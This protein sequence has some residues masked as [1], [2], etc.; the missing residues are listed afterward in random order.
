[1]HYV[2]GSIVFNQNVEHAPLLPV[3][4]SFDV[5]TN[6]GAVYTCYFEAFV[7]GMF[8]AIGMKNTGYLPSASLWSAL[9]PTRNDTWY[10]HAISQGTVDDENA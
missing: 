4:S 7:R 2:L 1:M 9:P 5:R 10:R 6:P 3:C 8:A